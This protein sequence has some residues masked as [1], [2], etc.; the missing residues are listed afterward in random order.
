MASDLEHAAIAVRRAIV[1]KFWK[2]PLEDLLVT[3]ESRF[4]LIQ[5]E[6]RRA[7]GSRDDLLAALRKAATYPGFW[8]VLQEEGR[9]GG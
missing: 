9:S 8:D 4:L 5:H 7:V 2:T 6:G 3:A 1:E